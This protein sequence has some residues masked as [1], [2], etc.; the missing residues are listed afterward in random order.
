MSATALQINDAAISVALAPLGPGSLGPGSLGP[1][2]L[3]E[4]VEHHGLVTGE[5]LARARLVQ[6]ET[7]ERFAAILT[8]LGLVSESA[9]AAAA[10]RATGLPLA[11]TGD[12]GL[13][14]AVDRISER[15]LREFKAAVLRADDGVCDVAVVDPFDPYPVSAIR[16][17]LGMPVR[18]FVGRSSDIEAAIDRAYGPAMAADAA[19]DDAADEADL[20]RLKDLASDAPAIRAINWLITAA[21]EQR[22]SDIHLEATEDGIVVRF[23]IDGEMRTVETLPAAMRAPL[24]SRIK[25]M[26]GLNIAERRLPQDGRLRLAV[27]GHDIDLRVATSPT[28]NGESAVLRLLDRS[29]LTLDFAALGFDPAVLAKLRDT[30]ALPNGIVLATGP[31][32]SGKTTTLYAALTELNA[33]NRKILTIEDPIE[34]RL[35]GVN[36]MQVNPAIGLDF[37]T[38]LRSF[39]RQDPDVIMVGEIRDIETAQVAVHAALTGHM[40][41][42]TLHTNTAASAVTRLLD[43]GVEPFLIAS[44]LSAVLAQ[45]LV[46]RLCP[47]CREAYDPPVP[48]GDATTLYRAVGCGE[49]DHTGYRGR[50]A[51]VEFL[52]VD[53]TIAKLVLARAE[54]RDIA[55]ASAATS[56]YADGIAKARAGLTTIEEVLRVTRENGE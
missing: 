22:S 35:A 44:T 5:T 30:L 9:L 27:R 54:A 45:R 16:L 42:S 52:V 37:A 17:A 26:A 28:I 50:I 4:L 38:A 11:A 23:R 48:V 53:A 39:L 31:T 40:I 20:E 13:P 19:I 36:Q 49:C 55:A 18:V 41:L 47:A 12:F 34:Y 8:R 33:P 32:G 2:S 7:G 1:G 46:R 56:M 51:L 10:A 43:M 6:A 25:V 15:F 21:V 3:D 29:N 14:V 24:V